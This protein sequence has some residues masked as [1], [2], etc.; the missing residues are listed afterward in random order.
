M[1]EKRYV[2]CFVC[3]RDFEIKQDKDK[4]KMWGRCPICK[5]VYKVDVPYW[6]K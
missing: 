4:G 3:K 1:E 6:K 5:A 2:T